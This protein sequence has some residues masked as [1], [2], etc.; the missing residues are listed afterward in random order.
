MLLALDRNSTDMCGC[1]MLRD[2]VCCGIIYHSDDDED[3]YD[4]LLALLRTRK[5]R[6]TKAYSSKKPSPDEPNLD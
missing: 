3:H 6:K 5:P 2:G 4:L 1:K